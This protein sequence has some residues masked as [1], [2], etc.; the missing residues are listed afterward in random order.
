MPIH[1]VSEV[2]TYLQGIL[3]R[4]AFLTD[5]YVTGEVSN[6]TRAASGHYY[7]TIKDS[8]S[9]LRCVMFRPAAGSEF[10]EQGA[11]ITAHGRIGIYQVRGELQ[12][13]VDL[14]Q[15]EGVGELHLE[16]LRLKAK[17]E[18]EG[19]FDPSRK[20]PLPAYPKRIAVIT[21]RTGA[22]YH[23][24]QTVLGRRYP[25]VE[26]VLVHSTVQGDQAPQGIV[27]ALKTINQEPGIDIVIVA[28]GGGSLE[29]LWAFNEEV[30]ARAIHASR[31]PV[32]S[33]VGHETDETIADY[34]ADV[35][36]P[37][38]SAAAERVVPDRVELQRRIVELQAAAEGALM[39]RLR[40]HR[41][42]LRHAVTR[43]QH[44]APDIAARQQRLDELIRAATSAVAGWVNI[45]R[46][47]VR[48]KAL[49]LDTLHPGHTLARGYALV[50]R[51]ADGRI[52]SRV[53]DVQPGDGLS[54]QVRDGRFDAA[55]TGGP[56][57]V[58]P[59]RAPSRRSKKKPTPPEQ[60]P[61]WR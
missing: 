47:Q 43:L 49:Q 16:F 20:R 51:Q 27:S 11:R 33:A 45:V 25:L 1:T 39:E 55:V 46:E 26:L 36:A 50:E 29:E 40:E 19:L 8:E 60:A 28:R 53:G 5:L 3:E 24:I 15:P 44:L 34:V 6:L 10:L 17:L 30:V 54:V 61:L 42:D 22:V 35:R 32:V 52:V 2:V 38:P 4:D 14:V 7:F 37:T 21:S 59:T 48:G 57:P 41:D 18:E 13:V 9:Q 56:M 31:V 12:Y 58:S 23:D